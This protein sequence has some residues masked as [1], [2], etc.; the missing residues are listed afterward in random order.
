M[1]INNQANFISNMNMMNLMANCMNNIVKL[2]E[3]MNNNKKAQ[4]PS[5]KDNNNKGQK[6]S[7][8]PRGSET[9]SHTAF[10]EVSGKR[11]YLVFQATTGHK[12]LMNAPEFSKIGD[13]IIQYGLKIGVGPNIVEKEIQFLFNGCKIKKEDR[14]KT[15]GQLGILNHSTIL[16]ID[17]KNFIGG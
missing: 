1:D 7:N 12:V 10:P 2:Y 9:I 3:D 15:P 16:V 6:K 11:I 13:I 5:T 4:K 14:N 17:L 8:L